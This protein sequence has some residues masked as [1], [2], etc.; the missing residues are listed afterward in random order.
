MVNAELMPAIHQGWSSYQQLMISSLRPLTE[1]QLA[2]RASAHLRSVG[3][4]AQHIVE[5]RAHWFYD[6]MGEGGDLFENFTRWDDE[7]S[8]ARS[9]E[10]LISGLTQTWDI[11]DLAMAR[12]STVEWNQTWAGRGTAPKLITRQWVIW[13][14][15]EHDLHHGGEIS[16][17]LGMHGIQGFGM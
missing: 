15:L 4:L 11:M 2:L 9:A 1:A 3:E 16:L 13:H 12:W 5:A 7:G 17:T 8:A 14:L 10:E 6:L